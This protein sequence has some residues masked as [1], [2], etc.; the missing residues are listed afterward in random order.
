MEIKI[1]N[2]ERQKEN[3]KTATLSWTIPTEEG[4]KLYHS[5]KME[6]AKLLIEKKNGISKKN[7]H[8]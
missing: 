5:V 1:L 3:V 2:L 7:L 8:I 4:F 6:I